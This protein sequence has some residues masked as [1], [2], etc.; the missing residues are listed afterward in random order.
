M[1]YSQMLRALSVSMQAYLVELESL[2]HAILFLKLKAMSV[3]LMLLRWILFMKDENT[4][5]K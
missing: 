2:C 1:K 4:Y 3:S 5:I